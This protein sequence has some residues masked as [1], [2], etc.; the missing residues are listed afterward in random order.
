MKHVV[1]DLLV[2]MWMGWASAV[3]WYYATRWW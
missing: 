1:N 2:L 3:S